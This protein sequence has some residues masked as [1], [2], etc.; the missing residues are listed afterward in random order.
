[1]GATTFEGALDEDYGP[2]NR[3]SITCCHAEPKRL[4]QLL[5]RLNA[6][7]THLLP[8]TFSLTGQYPHSKMISR[9]LTS[10]SPMQNLRLALKT[11]LNI[12]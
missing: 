7:E 4:Q 8:A 2:D 3:K 12:A 10:F 1:M 6:L 9:K 5:K 11:A